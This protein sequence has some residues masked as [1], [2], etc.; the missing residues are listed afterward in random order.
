MNHSLH[1][2]SDNLGGFAHRPL[3]PSYSRQGRGR[4]LG[5]VLRSAEP[6]P[7]SIGPASEPSLPFSSRQEA[8]RQVFL[9]FI[10]YVVNSLTGDGLTKFS[11]FRLFGCRRDCGEQLNEDF[12]DHLIHGFCGSDLGIYLEA[13]EEMSNGLE[14]IGQGTVV[15]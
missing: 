3:R 5:P 2:A 6:H 14:Q 15:N 11:L 12:D 4:P 13:I 9:S 8:S 1:S 7:V 10:S